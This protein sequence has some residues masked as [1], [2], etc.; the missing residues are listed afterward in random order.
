M[1]VNASNVL[2]A[3]YAALRGS[4]TWNNRFAEHRLRLTWERF[5]QSA[6]ESEEDIT[7]AVMAALVLFDDTFAQL[8]NEAE[9][10]QLLALAAKAV[11]RYQQEIHPPIQLGRLIAG[12]LEES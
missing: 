12:T 8:L 5:K 9:R 10:S 6:W 7:P 4:P 2:R 3:L 11:E 1:N